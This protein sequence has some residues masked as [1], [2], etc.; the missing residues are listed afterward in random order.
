MGFA[1]SPTNKI[2]PPTQETSPNSA[3]TIIPTQTDTKQETKLSPNKGG[4]KPIGNS[5]TPTTVIPQTENIELK[6]AKCKAKEESS[7]T[8]SVQTINQTTD[9]RLKEIFAS[10]QKQYQDGVNDLYNIRDG[11]IT[12][13]END[14]SLTGVQKSSLIKQYSDSASEQAEILY[15]NQQTFWE[16]QKRQIEG[17]KQ[18][19]IDKI[20]ALISEQCNNCLGN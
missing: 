13:V 11:Q 18:N 12:R 3:F 10:L 4:A 2:T 8:S 6:I 14:S 17:S 20:K 1:P 16:N 5:V 9:T 19:S 15:K 7:Y